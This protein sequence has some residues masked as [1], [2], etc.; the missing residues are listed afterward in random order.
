MRRVSSWQ[1]RLLTF[2][3][4][5]IM[6]KH[7]LQTLPVYLLSAIRPPKRV[8]KSLHKIFSKYFW[9]STIDEKRKQW[10]AWDRMCL[11]LEEGGIGFRSLAEISKALFVKLWWNLRT[12]RSLWSSYMIK[13][14]CKKAHPMI[15]YGSGISPVC[16]N[17]NRDEGRS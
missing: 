15:V 11:P 12:S 13:K 2:G 3:G 14:Y 17:T 10:V 7:V 4:K 8:I 16:K 5:I 9:G 6:I 1:N